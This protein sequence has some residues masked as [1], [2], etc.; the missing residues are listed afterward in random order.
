[1]KQQT[2]KQNA[3]PTLVTLYKWRH[4]PKARLCVNNDTK[5]R[6]QQ[7][8][9]DTDYGAA[10]SCTV[11]RKRVM[12]KE[13]MYSVSDR[14]RMAAKQPRESGSGKLKKSQDSEVADEN[15]IK[16]LKEGLALQQQNNSEQETQLD[17]LKEECQEKVDYLEESQQKLN[18]NLKYSKVCSEQIIALQKQ[19]EKV[20]EESNTLIIEE[21]HS[22]AEFDQEHQKLNAIK[23]QRDNLAEQRGT[24]NQEKDALFQEVCNL[25]TELQ[26][27]E[28]GLQKLNERKVEYEKLLEHT[29]QVEGALEENTQ[30]KNSQTQE[31]N[32]LQQK[33]SQCSQ[34]IQA[35]QK[36]NEALC[37][38]NLM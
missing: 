1:M 22:Q 4:R 37:E 12:E 33:L 9:S 27:R 36:D 24:L 38:E 5:G 10:G 14:G 20:E 25:K 26:K 34:T 23:Q 13:G 21:L 18:K 15:Y 32:L 16:K 11:G 6:I 29:R 7:I 31:M 8:T 19:I 30:T 35:A 17:A 2:W 28:L 3:S